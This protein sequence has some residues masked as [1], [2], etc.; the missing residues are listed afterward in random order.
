MT[1]TTVAVS[2]A[3][4]FSRCARNLAQY[5]VIL[6]RGFHVSARA[7]YVQ[8]SVTLLVPHSKLKHV[9]S[10]SCVEVTAMG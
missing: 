2:S 7:L 8:V 6:H 4:L 5:D 3:K 9:V 1:E 10:S